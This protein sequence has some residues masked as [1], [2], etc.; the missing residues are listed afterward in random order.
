MKSVLNIHWNDWCWSWRSNTL[1]TWCEELTHWKRPQCWERLKTGV[2]GD[3]R[4][5]NGW[6]AS[7]TPW[8]WVW[9]SSG[10]WWPTGSLACCSPWG[11]KESDTIQWLNWT[12]MYA[13][14]SC[15]HWVYRDEYFPLYSVRAIL[16]LQPPLVLPLFSSSGQSLSCIFPGRGSLYKQMSF[17]EHLTSCTHHTPPETKYQQA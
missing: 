8:T 10:S 1:A 17:K 16:Y 2:E 6:M 11:R 9:V 12:Q 7:L 3:D 14:P 4:G 5:W 15:P 13:E